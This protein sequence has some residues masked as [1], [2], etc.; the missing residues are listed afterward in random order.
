MRKKYLEIKNGV[1]LR[2][3]GRSICLSWVIIQ[4][5]ASEEIRRIEGI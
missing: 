1:E 2:S 5:V 4:T 3:T